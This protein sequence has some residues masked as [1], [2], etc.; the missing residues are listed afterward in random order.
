MLD[1]LIDLE[2]E[3]EAFGFKWENATQIIA[4]AKSECDEIQQCIESDS[5]DR[6]LLQEEIGD[7]MHAAFSLCLFLNFD[8]YETLNGS[9]M[10]FEKRLAAVK[11][12]TKQAGLDSLEGK[13]FD[14]LMYFWKMAKEKLG[15]T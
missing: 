4:Q 7:L 2:N 1:K 8:P 6:S 3:A 11:L 12:L 10:K 5:H 14:E 13:P 9:V 15:D